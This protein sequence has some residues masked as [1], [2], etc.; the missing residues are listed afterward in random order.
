MEMVR[1]SNCPELGARDKLNRGSKCILL[2]HGEVKKD[3]YGFDDYSCCDKAWDPSQS[4][5]LAE[6]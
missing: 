6:V 3:E 5:G 4:C 2:W 1:Q